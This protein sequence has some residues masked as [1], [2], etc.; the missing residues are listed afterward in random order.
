MS[1][2]GGDVVVDQLLD[3]ARAGLGLGLELGDALLD[4]R[5]AGLGVLGERVDAGVTTLARRG[6]RSAS[7]GLDARGHVLLHAGEA[8]LGLGDESRTSSTA[9]SVTPTPA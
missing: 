6:S 3:L 8:L 9:R 7:G 4:R 5:A 2:G 1:V